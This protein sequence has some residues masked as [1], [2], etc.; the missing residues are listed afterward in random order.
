MTVRNTLVQ[1]LLVCLI[2]TL[3][4]CVFEFSAKGTTPVCRLLP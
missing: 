4:I 3:L 1:A 2:V